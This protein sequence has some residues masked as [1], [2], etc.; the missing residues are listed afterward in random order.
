MTI[1]KQQQEIIQNI[2]SILNKKIITDEAIENQLNDLARD[3]ENDFFTVVVLG[4]FKRGKSTFV[5]SLLGADLLPTDVL[6][7]TAVISAIAYNDTPGVEAVYQDGTTEKNGFQQV[8]RQTN[9]KIL[10]I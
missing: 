1:E 8:I 3:V 6:P 4:E 2:D 7:E 5:N 9:I 10:S